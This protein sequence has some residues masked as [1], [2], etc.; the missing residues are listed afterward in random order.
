M[1]NLQGVL[2]V[3]PRVYV[4]CSYSYQ[5]TAIENF[6]PW[7]KGHHGPKKRCSS[8]SNWFDFQGKTGM[9]GLGRVFWIHHLVTWFQIYSKLCYVPHDV[10][11]QQVWLLWVRWFIRATSHDKPSGHKDEVRMAPPLDSALWLRYDEVV[12]ITSRK[13]TWQWKI[14]ML[15]FRGV[16]CY[17]LYWI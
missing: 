4:E 14:T 7:K 1:L 9:L 13:L 10:S 12:D 5:R 3:I 11:V 6:A 15:V 17:W 16:L 2:Y 8:S